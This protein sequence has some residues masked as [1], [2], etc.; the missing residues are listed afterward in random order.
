MIC[1]IASSYENAKKFAASQHLEDN[2]WFWPNS[3]TNL[4][5]KSNFHVIT[6][7]FGIE[8][9]PNSKLNEL[10]TTAQK[11]GRIGRT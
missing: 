1:L 11:R 5:F 3:T 4:L 6:V 2:E 9:M 7:I 8:H 10:F